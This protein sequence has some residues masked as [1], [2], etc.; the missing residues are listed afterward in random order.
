MYFNQQNRIVIKDFEITFTNTM[1]SEV[2]RLKKT[3]DL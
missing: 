2:N 3:Q 1:D